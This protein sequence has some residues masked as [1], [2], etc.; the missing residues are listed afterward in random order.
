MWPKMQKVSLCIKCKAEHLAL[1]I[2]RSM[3]ALAPNVHGLWLTCSSLWTIN[4]HTHTPFTRGNPLESSKWPQINP[5]QS[6]GP[7]AANFLLHYR[8]MLLSCWIFYFCSLKIFTILLRELY[9]G[10]CFWQ[11]SLL[12][13]LLL[14]NSYSANSV[15]VTSSLGS[16]M[17]PRAPCTP[18]SH[19]LLVFAVKRSSLIRLLGSEHRTSGSCFLTCT[20]WLTVVE[21][22]SISPHPPPTNHSHMAAPNMSSWFRAWTS[23]PMS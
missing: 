14:D 22:F 18:L 2:Q 5:K 1:I 17:T 19:P 20:A 13:P 16:T 12:P 10:F 11:H 8:P 7:N 23:E 3:W 6:W 4:T 9:S 21:I 15:K